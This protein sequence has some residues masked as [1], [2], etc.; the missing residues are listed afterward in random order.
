M[1][2]KAAASRM[3]TR[4]KTPWHAHRST[5]RRPLNSVPI[6]RPLDTRTLRST[7]A[8]TQAPPLSPELLA[9][10]LTCLPFLLPLRDVALGSCSCSCSC[11]CCRRFPS[12]SSYSCP[13]HGWSLA[14]DVLVLPGQGEMTPSITPPTQPDP[15]RLGTPAL[16][17]TFGCGGHV[18][19]QSNDHANPQQG[20]N[21]WLAL[22]QF[23]RRSNNSTPLLGGSSQRALGVNQTS[24]SSS[25]D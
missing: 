3:H 10:L 8:R 25:S 4:I 16:F 21:R 18:N 1:A 23:Q 12:S 6:G 7:V 14:A 22:G 13:R 5:T 2:I 9:A 15:P 20:M 11:P 24:R 19:D 17:V